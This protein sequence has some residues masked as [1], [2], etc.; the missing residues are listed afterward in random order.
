MSFINEIEFEFEVGDSFEL[1]PIEGSYVVSKLLALNAE[2]YID[3]NTIIVTAIP[4]K[5]A[6]PAPELP[7]PPVEAPGLLDAP[8]IEEVVETPE[9]PVVEEAPKATPNLVPPIKRA[10]KP[11]S[12]KANVPNEQ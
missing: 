10:R 8:P 3:G 4:G 5:I 11:A 12:E 1:S 9:A 6:L 2:F 7:E